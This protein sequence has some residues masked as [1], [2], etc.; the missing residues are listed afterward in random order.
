MQDRSVHEMQDVTVDPTVVQLPNTA[1]EHHE[2]TAYNQ[3]QQMK[4]RCPLPRYAR[5]NYRHEPTIC[6]EIKP[7]YALLVTKRGTTPPFVQPAP[8]LRTRSCPQSSSHR[9][10]RYRHPLHPLH[11]WSHTSRR[12]L[13]NPHQPSPVNAWVSDCH[14]T[15]DLGLIALRLPHQESGS[16]AIQRIGRVGISQELG[17]E[18]LEDVDHIEHG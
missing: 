15:F 11:P 6:P 17:Q 14:C 3:A 16:L 13:R 7:M 12:I 5:F 8:H 4:R 18:D 1:T 10:T 2:M 9:P